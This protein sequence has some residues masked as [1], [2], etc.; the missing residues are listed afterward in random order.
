MAY[1][2]T[3]KFDTSLDASG[4]QKGADRL[5]DII[6]GLGIFDVLKK[7]VQ[8]VADSVQAAMGRLDTMDQFN[9]VMTTMTGSADKANEALSKTNEIVSGTAYG[10]D[11]ASK[12]VQAF[13]ASG[14]EVSKATDTMGAWA[15]AV[16]FYTKGT[17]SELETVSA[18]LQKMQTKGNVTM[19]HLQMLLEAGVPAIQIYASAVG[20]STEEITEQMSKGQLKTDDFISV[21]NAAFETGTAGFPSI[22]GAAKEAGASW[23]GSI[24][25]MNAAITRGTASILTSF[26]K[27]FNVKAGMVSFGKAIE[28]VLKGIADNMDIIAPGTLTAAGAFVSYKAALGISSLISSVSKA[29]AAFTAVLAFQNGTATALTATQMAQNAVLTALKAGN[30]TAAASTAGLTAA[31]T[32]QTAIMGVLSGEITFATAVQY[33][34]NAAMEANPIGAIIALIALLIT[35]L[36]ALTAALGRGSEAYQ[37]QKEKIDA[38]NLSL[39]H[40]WSKHHEDILNI[41]VLPIRVPRRG[42]GRVVSCLGE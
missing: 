22:A 26:D 42:N 35:G 28:S 33:L 39:I 30:V 31:Q 38:L 17:N 15:D 3:L 37:A 14:M 9:R 40:I 27:M 2:G 8:M 6:K 29:S 19:E 23:S 24:D 7:G 4:M 41:R 11:T 32:V 13:V 5:G 10:L 12:G 36:V 1:D 34:W 20:K 21:M 25:N 18:A 16:S